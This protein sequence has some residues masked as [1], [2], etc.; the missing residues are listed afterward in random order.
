MMLVW[1]IGSTRMRN[2]KPKISRICSWK[3]PEKRMK[4][5]L[6]PP[7]LCRR[8]KFSIPARNTWTSKPK[9]W[10]PCLRWAVWFWAVMWSHANGMGVIPN[11]TARCSTRPP[12]GGL[13]WGQSMKLFVW[14]STFYGSNIICSLGMV[15][16]IWTNWMQ[17]RSEVVFPTGK[18]KD[19][20][21]TGELCAKKKHC[22]NMDV[23]WLSHVP[24]FWP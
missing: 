11:W 10:R 13:D 6:S 4:V 1:L 8:P 16:T 2:W 22:P 5:L 15:R 9:A 14:A 12:N 17:L 18:P 19:L 7:P 21:A 3:W 20:Y 23:P 24:L